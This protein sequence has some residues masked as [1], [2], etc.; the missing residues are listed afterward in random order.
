MENNDSSYIKLYKKYKKKYINLR[1]EFNKSK[2]VLEK[3]DYNYFFVHMAFQYSNFIGILT[4]G[5][6]YPGKDLKYEQRNFAADKSSEYVFTNIY[7]EDLK[8]LPGPKQY[9][10]IL[11]P[12][13]LY[14]YGFYFNE[15]WKGDVMEDSLCVN[16]F[17]SPKQIIH[18]LNIIR[19]FLTGPPFSEWIEI[20]NL[21]SHEILFDHPIDLSDGNL[22]AIVCRNATQ[23]QLNE[24]RKIIKNKPYKN[25][26]IITDG[27]EFPSLDNMI[28]DDL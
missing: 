13:I 21:M 4:D 17:D 10:F 27:I 7:F 24:I 1:D 16:T 3:C 15:Q 14:K 22:L 23:N 28:Y 5:I 9:S 25:V 20:N 8:N 2:I 19:K 11:H 26:L 6:I 18:K 12:K